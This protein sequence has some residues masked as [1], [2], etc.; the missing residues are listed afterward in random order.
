MREDPSQTVKE[1]IQKKTSKKKPYTPNKVSPQR[2][3]SIIK[4]FRMGFN[5]LQKKRLDLKNSGINT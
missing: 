4:E 1:V 5:T 3:F 2:L